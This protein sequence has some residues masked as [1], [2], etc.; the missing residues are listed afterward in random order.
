[1]N[2]TDLKGRP[3]FVRE[4]REEGTAAA[5]HLATGIQSRRLYVGNLSYDVSW[6]DLKDHFKQC[7]SVVRADVMEEPGGRSKGCGLIEYATAEQAQLAMVTLKDTD[8]KG[9]PI[10]VREDREEGAVGGGV[11]GVGGGGGGGRMA[12]RVFVGNLSYDVSWQS[13]KDHFK[14]VGVVIRSDVA[15]GDDG[16]SR[17]YGIVELKTPRDA[18]AAIAHLNNSVLMGRPITVR[19]DGK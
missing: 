11:G 2:D 16:R 10:F 7:G 19:E 15:T 18:M 14:Q 4:D 5:K 12:S 1:M 6:Q 9:R 17:G 13:L 3:I 8:L